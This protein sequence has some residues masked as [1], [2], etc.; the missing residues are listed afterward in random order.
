MVP[1]KYRTSNC[2]V[3]RTHWV[4]GKKIPTP[5]KS[6]LLRA[7]LFSIYLARRVDLQG[8]TGFVFSWK[9]TDANGWDS[10]WRASSVERWT[11]KECGWADIVRACRGEDETEGKSMDRLRSRLRGGS[12][13]DTY[14][15]TITFTSRHND[16]KT[17]HYTNLNVPVVAFCAISVIFGKLLQVRQSKQSSAIWPL[18]SVQMHIPKLV[19]WLHCYW[20]QG[21]HKSAQSQ[22]TMIRDWINMGVGTRKETQLED[23]DGLERWGQKHVHPIY[24]K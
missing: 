2:I 7:R 5:T 22:D 14:I 13:A 3:K 12:L 1:L 18:V 6:S 15:P 9:G 4:C 8:I 11:T 17:S 10:Q 20:H 19:V 24:P 21:D 23:G 16:G